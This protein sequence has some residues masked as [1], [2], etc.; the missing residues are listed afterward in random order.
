MSSLGDTQTRT[1][2]CPSNPALTVCR[3]AVCL[4]TP[5]RSLLERLSDTVLLSPGS[6]P[7]WP[8]M[9][10]LTLHSGSKHSSF[11]WAA[12]CQGGPHLHTLSLR[13]PRFAVALLSALDACAC[14]MTR[15]GHTGFILDQQHHWKQRLNLGIWARPPAA[16]LFFPQPPS[17]E[18]CKNGVSL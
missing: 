12:R 5:L 15:R 3:D 8:L 13:G 4:F 11:L 2:R 7:A 6:R 17:N 10:L 1:G 9:E 14:D 18:S 16:Y